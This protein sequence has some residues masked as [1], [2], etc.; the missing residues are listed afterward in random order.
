M[1]HALRMP[2]SRGG[3]PSRHDTVRVRV[4]Q[5][6]D[7]DNRGGDKQHVPK[8]VDAARQSVA[9]QGNQHHRRRQQRQREL[10]AARTDALGEKCDERREGRNAVQQEREGQREHNQDAAEIPQQLSGTIGQRPR[11]RSAQEQPKS[12]VDAQPR[13][14]TRGR[15]P[16]RGAPAEGQQLR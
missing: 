9:V 1:P 12:A 14:H 11:V 5:R 7:G 16:P 3:T 4:E 6:V 8:Q 2:L 13:Q 10:R 15:K